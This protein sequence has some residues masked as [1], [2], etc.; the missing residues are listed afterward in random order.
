MG[1]VS[2]SPA[3][4]ISSCASHTFS[5]IFFYIP[6]GP[7]STNGHVAIISRGF[8]LYSWQNAISFMDIKKDINAPDDD[9]V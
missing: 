4:R 1:E 8:L 7:F 2:T 3:F 9:K 5:W 6:R